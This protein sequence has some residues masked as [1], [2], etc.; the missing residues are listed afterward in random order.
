MI[1]EEYVQPEYNIIDGRRVAIAKHITETKYGRT[2]DRLDSPYGYNQ[3]V[4]ARDG[5]SQS[6]MV[7]V[8]KGPDGS[9]ERYAL[10]QRSTTD[11]LVA[12]KCFKLT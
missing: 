10:V 6:A 4:T 3:T 2:F 12:M 5:S 1:N 9:V 8:T 11:P 7:Y